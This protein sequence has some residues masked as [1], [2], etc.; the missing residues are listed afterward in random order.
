M[1]KWIANR[2]PELSKMRTPDGQNQPNVDMARHSRTTEC[3]RGRYKRQRMATFCVP[4]N[5]RR[6]WVERSVQQIRL[7]TFPA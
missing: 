4:A 1:N 3:L 5:L 2:E 6:S 7:K